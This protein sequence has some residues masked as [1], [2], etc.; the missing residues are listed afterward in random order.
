MKSGWGTYHMLIAKKL[1]KMIML[2]GRGW[3]RQLCTDFLWGG[4]QIYSPSP[5]SFHAEF[6]L[7]RC[8]IFP[9]LIGTK[10]FNVV[11]KSP[12]MEKD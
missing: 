2:L 8:F 11:Y 7:D 3:T 5:W 1:H 12:L 6:I 9:I 4:T 10:E